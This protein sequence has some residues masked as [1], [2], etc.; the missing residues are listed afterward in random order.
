MAS[1]DAQNVAKEV[2]EKLGKGEK[3]SLGE[4]AR[5]N[6]YALSTADNPRNIT[7][8]ESYQRVLRPVLTQLESERQAILDRLPEVREKAKYRDLVEG[9]D[10]ISKNIQLLS[11]GATENIAVAGDRKSTRL[12]SSHSQI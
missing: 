4:I 9:L 2:L 3:I 1:V 6:G 5:K 12:N 8:T 11:G 10:K 7:E